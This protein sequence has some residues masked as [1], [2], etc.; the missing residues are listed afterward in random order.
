MN[1]SKLDRRITIMRGTMTDDG[2]GGVLTSYWP[3]GTIWAH[4]VDV[5][6]AEKFQ[7]GGINATLTS[8]FTVRSSD[9]SRGIKTT[10]RLLHDG[11]DWN[12]TGLKESADGRLRFIEIS[13][14]AENNG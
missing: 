3:I 8:R 13:A 2:F 10:D 9:F 1:A 6:D 12:V 4:R 11:L 5:K 7:Y 14:T